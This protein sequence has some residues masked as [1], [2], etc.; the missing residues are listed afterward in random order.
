[1]SILIMVQWTDHQHVAVVA[2]LAK[3]ILIMVGLVVIVVLMMLLEYLKLILCAV[4]AVVELL[5]QLHHM[6]LAVCYQ[7]QIPMISM[8]FIQHSQNLT[9][10]KCSKLW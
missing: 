6:T 2:A 8:Y 9:Q 4:N 3:T 10:Q 1:M 7:S 5:I